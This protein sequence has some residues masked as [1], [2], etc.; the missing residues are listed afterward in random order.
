MGYRNSRRIAK[1]IKNKPKESSNKKIKN[2]RLTK[3]RVNSFEKK[4]QRLKKIT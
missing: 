2:C 1:N 4:R 3:P